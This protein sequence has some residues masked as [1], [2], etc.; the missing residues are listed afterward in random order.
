MA[1]R[2]SWLEAIVFMTLL[3]G[4]NLHLLTGG[5]PAALVYDQAAVLAGQWWRLFTH[6][7][8]HVSRYHLGLDALAVVILWR[9]M[10]LSVAAKIGTFLVCGIASLTGAV[11][12]SPLIGQTGL[13]GLS[14]IAHGLMV[15]AGVL[16]LRRFWAEGRRD[17]RAGFFGGI[18]CAAG[19]GKSLVEVASGGALLAGLH[20]GDLG[21]PIVEAHLGGALGGLV[22]GLLLRVRGS[23]R[24]SRAIITCENKPKELACGEHHARGGR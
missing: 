2:R 20:G 6:P 13:C 14:G 18:L 9:L 16:A 3:V 24:S 19:L 10:P 8:V 4:C 22:A 5:P 17:L 1:L 7:L 23:V 15:V 11:L 21:I 12:F